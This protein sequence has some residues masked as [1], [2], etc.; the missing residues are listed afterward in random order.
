MNHHLRQI[1]PFYRL[2]YVLGLRHPLLCPWYPSS[3]PHLAVHP[4]VICSLSVTLC[5]RASLARLCG[6]CVDRW[7]RWVGC[8][9]VGFFGRAARACRSSVVQ[10]AGDATALPVDAS[11]G[12]NAA[13][14]PHGASRGLLAAALPRGA[15]RG[16]GGCSFY[17]GVP[18]VASENS[19]S[20]LKFNS[21]Y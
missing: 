2:S 13:A 9:C 20:L 18:S 10:R 5:S 14:L 3:R 17:R 12:L 15:S 8:G 7:G 19:L 4:R 21:N 1:P 6:S 11:R 16:R